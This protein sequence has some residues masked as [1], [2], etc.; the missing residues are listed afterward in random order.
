MNLTRA[1]ELVYDAVLTLAYPQICVMCG[2]SVEQRRFGVACKTCWNETRI[3]T[4]DETICWKCGLPGPACGR[5]DA[6]AF[7]AARAAGTYQGALRES[8]LLLK[9]QPYVPRHVGCLLEVAVMRE[10]LRLSTRVIPVPLHP[11]RL[12]TRGFN[13]AS[14]VGQTVSK[15]L[16]L[17]LDE[18]SL[19]RVSTT[20]KYRAGMDAKGRRDTVAG[21]FHV[22]HPRLVAGENIL[23]VDDVF[24]TGAT[25]SACAAALINSG[26]R[27]V[28]VLT[29]GRA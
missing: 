13:Q 6:L 2:R 28:F 26:A 11:K 12:R 17:P 20:E 5:C 21:A 27:D 15:A 9:R 10:P 29:I 4:E 23:L 25:V 16:E 19:V 3:F 24:T 18:V 1:G 14:M 8:V 7:T 22:A